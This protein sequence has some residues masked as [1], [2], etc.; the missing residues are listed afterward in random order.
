MTKEKVTTNLFDISLIPK[1]SSI[2]KRVKPFGKEDVVK[3]RLYKSYDPK[4]KKYTLRDSFIPSV[5]TVLD[6]AGNTYD[7]GYVTG[8]AIGGAPIFGD[9]MF[10]AGRM[11]VITLRGESAKDKRLYDYLERCNFNVSNEHRDVNSPALFERIEANSDSIVLRNERKA[12][13]QAFDLLDEMD[14]KSITN[15]MKVNNIPMAEDEDGRRLMVEEYIDKVGPETFLKSSSS[16]GEVTGLTSTVEKLKKDEVIAFSKT[17]K[18]WTNKNKEF[19][20]SVPKGEDSVGSLAK[21]FSSKKGAEVLKS[22]TD[23]QEEGE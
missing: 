20:H 3:Y 23:K 13:R 4:T 14:D 6:E 16:G 22:L 17:T 9:I 12:K 7:I 19:I 11:C 5:D 8:R 1:E 2:N 10:E 18:A 21:F 15:F